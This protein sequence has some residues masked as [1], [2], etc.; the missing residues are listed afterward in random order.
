MVDDDVDLDFKQGRSSGDCDS[1]SRLHVGLR[2]T[3]GYLIGLLS[4]ELTARS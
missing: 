2:P 1:H 4:L 3:T